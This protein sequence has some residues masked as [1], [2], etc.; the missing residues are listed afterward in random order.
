MMTGSVMERMW[1]RCLGMALMAAMLA[2][3]GGS[4][5]PAPPTVAAVPGS[6][7]TVY[8]GSLDKTFYAM[9]ARTGAI[10]W[11]HYIGGVMIGAPSWSPSSASQRLTVGWG[12]PTRSATRVTC[13]SAASAFST[14]SFGAS[15]NSS[16]N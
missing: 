9:D 10:R 6:P 4:E 14:A 13:S 5:P 15:S 12:S 1:T 11:K 7:P 8:I 16:T 2:A 3:C